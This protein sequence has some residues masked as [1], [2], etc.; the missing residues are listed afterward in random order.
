M[1]DTLLGDKPKNGEP[2][3][4]APHAAIG[5]MLSAQREGGFQFAT[6]RTSVV[7]AALSTSFPQGIQCELD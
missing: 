2:A 5:S 1:R 4:P 6:G 7:C 3:I